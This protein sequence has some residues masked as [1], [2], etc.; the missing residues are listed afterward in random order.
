MT[1]ENSQLPGRSLQH[2]LAAGMGATI[3]AA[4]VFGSAHMARSDGGLSDYAQPAIKDISAALKVEWK[5]DKE[6]SRI[7]K[8]YEEAYKLSNQSIWCKE[9]NQVRVEGHKGPLTVRFLTDGS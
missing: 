7:G 3:A 1:I 5:S 8:G 9:P 4:L 6:L 2:R